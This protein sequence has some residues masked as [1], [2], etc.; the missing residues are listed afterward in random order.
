MKKR[1]NVIVFNPIIKYNNG[2]GAK[3]CNKCRII[4]KEN[5]TTNELKG[6]TDLLLCKEC[7]TKKGS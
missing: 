1:M 2:R 6:K 5:L 3:L 7:K 4:I